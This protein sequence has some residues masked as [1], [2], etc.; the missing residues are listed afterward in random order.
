MCGEL[1]EQSEKRINHF[2]LKEEPVERVRN[3]LVPVE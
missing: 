3:D 2:K 1:E